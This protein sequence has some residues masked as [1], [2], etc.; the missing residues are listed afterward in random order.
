MLEVYNI[1]S[2]TCKCRASHFEQ[3]TSYSIHIHEVLI[4]NNKQLVI[5]VSQCNTAI[6]SNTCIET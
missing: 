6:N 1:I 3:E 4:F 2:Y 5:P